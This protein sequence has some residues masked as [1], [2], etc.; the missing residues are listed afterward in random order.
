N[1][2]L[3][4]GSVVQP[5]AWIMGP[6]II[7]KNCEIR[8]G[9]FVG[10]NILAG[11]NV[12]LGHASEIG[13]A[14]FLNGSRAPHFAFVGHSILGKNVNL[15]A[16]TKL[17]NLKVTRKEIEVAGIKTG[18][19]KI[20]AIIGDNS[21]FGCNTVTQPATFI[22]KNVYSYPLSLLSG[23]IESNQIIK[24]RPNQETTPFD[25]NR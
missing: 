21:S 16:G 4:E 3:G 19:T 7:G 2:Y 1:V 13:N 15:G 22:G 25:P 17:S 24:V 18:L 8:H 10:A 14:V 9:C 11:D 20:G 23:F 5:G 12:I 6:A